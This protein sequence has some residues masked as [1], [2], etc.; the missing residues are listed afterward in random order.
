MSTKK[1]ELILD[2]EAIEKM[3]LHSESLWIIE[4]DLNSCIVI[5]KNATPQEKKEI[6]ERNRRAEV[7]RNKM[8]FALKFKI[9]ATKHLESSWLIAKERLEDAQAELTAIKEEMKANG[10]DNVDKRIRIIPILTTETG[11]ENFQDM[12]TQFLLQFA[13]EH[14]AYCD[15]GLDE[16]RLPKSSLWR[17]KKAYEIINTLAEELKSDD[18]K[19][20][21]KDTVNLLDDKIQQVEAMLILQEEEAEAEK[22]KKAK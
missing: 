3:G 10:F 19:N 9:M 12:K 21:V 15:K 7:I 13:T 5:P 16:Q 4:Y 6:T 14:I 22:A 18:A 8:K 17:C 2:K 20:E 11:F 1:D